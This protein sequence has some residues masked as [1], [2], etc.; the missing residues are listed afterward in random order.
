MAYNGINF[1]RARMAPPQVGVPGGSMRQQ[2]VQDPAMRQAIVQQAAPQGVAEIL[3]QS[4][5][6]VPPDLAGAKGG[7]SRQREIAD[8]LTNRA[9]G[10]NATGIV[11]GFAQ[12]GEAFL[13]NKANRKADTAEAKR[14]EI[15]SMLTQK[16]AQGDEASIAA[17]LSPEAAIGRRDQQARYTVEDAL[18][19]KQ[20]GLQERGVN[21]D[22]RGLEYNMMDG[23]RTFGL[24]TDQFTEGKR[25]FDLGYGL[26]ERTVKAAEKEATSN[27]GAGSYGLNIVW[28]TDAN[29]N[30]VAMQ[31]SKGGGLQVAQ[32][33]DGV[34]L[35]DPYAT[36]LDRKLGTAAAEAEAGRNPA[37][38]GVLAAEAD[39]ARLGEQIDLAITQTDKGNTGSFGQYNVFAGDLAGTLKTI[40]ASGAFTSLVNLK[41]QGGTLGALS[42]TELQLLEAKIANVERSQSEEQLDKNLAELKNALTQSSMRIRAAYEKEYAA[43][44]YGRGGAAAPPAANGGGSRPVGPSGQPVPEGFE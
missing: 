5:G 12:L 39:M 35:L 3:S 1:N 17:L 33:P 2:V 11:D 18:A 36:A 13:A 24:Q 15:V 19:N 44:R 41:A 26:D 4:L 14:D 7:A 21:L 23:D 37:E 43:G 16:A 8:L 31:P 9:M 27:G 30:A 25:Q 40:R 20:L 32:T 29:G 6:E 38:Q 28:G 10:R 34:S 42:D 22:E